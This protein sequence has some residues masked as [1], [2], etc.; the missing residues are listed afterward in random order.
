ML[1]AR[2]VTADEAL[3]IGLVDRL[4]G[5]DVVKEALALAAELVTSSLP[6]QLA[7]VRAVNA[8]F[9]LPLGEGLRYEALLEQGLFVDGE[10][11]EGIR[12]FIAKR[13]PDFAREITPRSG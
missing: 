4:A 2:Q 8:A 7:V 6:A 12:A 5:G 13:A 9:E 3:A 11:V 1:T 10:A